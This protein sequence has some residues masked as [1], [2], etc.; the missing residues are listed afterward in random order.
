MLSPRKHNSNHKTN[1]ISTE[2][3]FQY[4]RDAV[5]FENIFATW[6]IILQIHLFDETEI[7]NIFLKNI[8]LFTLFTLRHATDHTFTQ[9][10]TTEHFLIPM[11]KFQ[12]SNH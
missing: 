7:F 3:V 11:R 12:T 6:E 2:N 4:L 1:I 9:S 5:S 8:K 10:N